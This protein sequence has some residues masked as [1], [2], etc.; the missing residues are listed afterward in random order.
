LKIL[1]KTQQMH[2]D[3][4]TGSDVRQT[5]RPRVD[6]H[7][8]CAKSRPLALQQQA[9]SVQRGFTLVELMVVLSLICVLTISATA[10]IIGLMQMY[11]IRRFV[12]VNANILSE[13]RISALL[14]HTSV[15]VCGSSNGQQCDQQWSVGVLSFIDHNDN[16][17]FNPLTDTA[18]HFE[19]LMLQYGQVEWR[20]FGSRKLIIYDALTGTP[21]ASN[22]SLTYCATIPTH[23]RQLILSRMGRVREST[24]ANHD[25]LHE[26][27]SGQPIACG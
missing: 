1:T 5:T 12:S 2:C 3:S 18:L 8:F 17:E 14:Y 13:A 24:D 4:T 10:S 27:A 16:R 21:N 9:I 19:P 15:L 22:G 20:G 11:D 6:G 23:H 7:F 25:G 26:D